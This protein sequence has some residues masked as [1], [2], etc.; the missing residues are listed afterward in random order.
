MRSH[1][2][3]GGRLGAA[4]STAYGVLSRGLISGHWSKERA[5]EKNFRAAL[6]RFQG[7]NLD[8][9][10]A[11]VERLRRIAEEKGVTVA[12]LAIAWV[13]AQGPDI[14]PLIGGRRRD[15]LNEAS[16]ARKIQLNAADLAALEQAAEGVA[17]DRYRT[18]QMAMLDSERG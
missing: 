15:R 8:A 11:V 16:A 3:V 14:V 7:A 10:L 12:Q 4:E 17:G 9:N 5:G 2:V 18:E 6:P 13:L 1:T